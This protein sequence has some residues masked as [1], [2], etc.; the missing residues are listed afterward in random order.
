M[1]D[2][3]EKQNEKTNERRWFTC[4]ICGQKICQFSDEAIAMELYIKCKKCG[5]EIE[6]R[7]NSRNEQKSA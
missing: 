5:N 7:I 4:P 1:T 3:N 2:T 6:I